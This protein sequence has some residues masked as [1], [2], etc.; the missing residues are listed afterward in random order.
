MGLSIPLLKHLLGAKGYGSFSI[1]FNGVLIC[2]AILSGWITQSVLRLYHNSENKAVFFRQTI[3]ISLITQLIIAVPVLLIVWYISNDILLALFFTIALFIICFQFPVMAISQSGFLSKKN[4]Y[5]ET[6]R[7]VTYISV[8]IVLLEFSLLHYMY[9][10]FTA[11]ILSY[12]FS[13]L[14]LYW[15]IKQ[16]TNEQDKLPAVSISLKKIAKDFFHYGA[17]LSGWFVFAYM[18]TYIDKLWVIKNFGGEVQG[19]YQAIFDLLSRTLVVVV[20]PVATSLFP[21]LTLAY[22]QGEVIA[23]KNLL[24]KIIFF[25]LAGFLLVSLL[26]WWFGADLV[27]MILKTENTITNKWVGFLIIAGTFSWLIAVVVHK[28]YELRM[29]MPNWPI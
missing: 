5:S 17:P 26:Y 22:K 10:L 20:S 1:W 14:Y 25:E 13:V 6:I 8:A 11:V 4:I 9:G 21:L 27:F 29:K 18:S 12:L 16:H 24:K 7:A 19:N 15:Q 23:I 2:A 3:R 28:K